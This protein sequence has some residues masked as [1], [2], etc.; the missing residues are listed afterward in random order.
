MITNRSHVDKVLG[1]QKSDNS[2]KN[3]NRPRNQR[4][5]IVTI[6]DVSKVH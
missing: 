6:Q 1:F 3:K 5:T 4:P 2:K